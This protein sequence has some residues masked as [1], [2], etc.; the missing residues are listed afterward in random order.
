MK[1]NSSPRPLKRAESSEASF[2]A[3]VRRFPLQLAR[4]P[5]EDLLLAK[6]T[7]F[8]KLAGVPP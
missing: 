7:Q 4:P 2:W 5:S 3:V 6:R 1:T 8:A